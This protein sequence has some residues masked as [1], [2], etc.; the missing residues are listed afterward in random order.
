M[1]LEIA[2]IRYRLLEHRQLHPEVHV[3]KS[4]SRRSFYEPKDRN[5]FSLRFHP[6]FAFAM[7]QDESIA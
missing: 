2:Y 1:D 5:F 4:V 6:R 7:G 3:R